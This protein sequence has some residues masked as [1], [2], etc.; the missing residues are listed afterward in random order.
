MNTQ[1]IIKVV[2]A[3]GVPVLTTLATLGVYTTLKGKTKGK[4]ESTEPAAK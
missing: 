2:K 4:E 1:L 3:V